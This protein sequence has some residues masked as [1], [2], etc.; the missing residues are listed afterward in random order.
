[1]TNFEKWKKELTLEGFAE[2]MQNCCRL[3]PAEADP[4]GE[5]MY[6]CREAIMLWGERE[7]PS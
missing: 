2:K 7:V 6:T 5:A 3:C 4:C 1:M